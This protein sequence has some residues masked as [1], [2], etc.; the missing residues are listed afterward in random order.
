MPSIPFERLGLAISPQAVPVPSFSWRKMD[1]YRYPHRR[2]C[3]VAT[4]TQSLRSRR[5]SGIAL[6]AFLPLSTTTYI[7][8]LRT[9]S[10]VSRADPK[11]HCTSPNIPLCFF[12]VARTS[13]TYKISLLC[14]RAFSN[15]DHQH[16]QPFRDVHQRLPTSSVPALLKVD[17][18]NL[19]QLAP[20]A[21]N[22]DVQHRD[23]AKR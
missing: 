13:E 22:S 8:A 7:W 2:P 19:R 20:P 21:R 10:S 12:A 14:H 6:P 16:S 3:P 23:A 9:P 4:S 17:P 11:T 5:S 1:N 15:Q 18:S